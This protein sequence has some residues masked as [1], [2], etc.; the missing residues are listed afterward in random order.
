[1]NISMRCAIIAAEVSGGC[2]GAPSVTSMALLEETVV[3]VRAG[4]GGWLF[5]CRLGISTNIS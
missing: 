3:A 2:V 1:M 4:E 5:V